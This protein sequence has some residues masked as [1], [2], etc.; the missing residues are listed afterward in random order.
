M[1]LIEY[2]KCSSK[3]NTTTKKYTYKSKQIDKKNCE[4]FFRVFSLKEGH[5]A[6]H[7]IEQYG[8]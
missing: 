5:L 8:K 7:Q 2:K 6:I 4:M 1:V 3:Q